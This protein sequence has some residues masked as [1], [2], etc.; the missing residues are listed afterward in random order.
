MT[1]HQLLSYIEQRPWMYLDP[2]SLDSLD[3]YIAGF[4]AGRG[5]VAKVCEENITTSDL[6]R[7][8]FHKWVVVELGPGINPV[9]GWKKILKQ[10]FEDEEQ[11]LKAFFD[12]YNSLSKIKGV[13]YSLG[14]VGNHGE[15]KVIDYQEHNI[16]LILLYDGG[17][18]HCDSWEEVQN[19]IKYKFDSNFELDFQKLLQS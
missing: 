10:K 9:Y 15:F 1:L 14:V 6:F 12:L 18:S 7:N 13:S 2:V 19:I 3:H 8:L 4:L 16:G 17:P 11:R 5:P